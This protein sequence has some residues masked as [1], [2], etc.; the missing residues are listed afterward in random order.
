MQDR[1]YGSRLNRRQFLKLAGA[2]VA[3]LW[4]F[5][6]GSGRARGPVGAGCTMPGREGGLW[7]PR[8]YDFMTHIAEAEVET[9]DPAY[10]QAPEVVWVA[11]EGRF[12]LFAHAPAQVTFR[13]VLVN[14]EGRLEFGVGIHQE[15]WARSGD[16]VRFIVEG[17]DGA[18]RRH[19]LYERHLSPQVRPEDR[20][21][22]DE[23]VDLA[24]FAG[25]R[26]HF[27]FRT[28]PG[29]NN[30][31]DWAVWSQPRLFS[32]LA[33]S[34][35]ATERPNIVL[36]T[37]DTL[38]A[39][40]VSCYGYPRQTTPTLDRLAAEGVRFT[41]AYSQ[42]DHTNPSHTTILTGMYPRS[43]SVTSNRAALPLEVV[44][45]PERL[46]E[47][48]YQTMGA[49]SS[50]HLGPDW[51]MDQG[52]DDYY[53][54]TWERRQGG[55]TTEV[56]LEW[57]IE[58]RQE[59][60]FMWVH[61]FDPHAPYL[62][63]YP[64]NVLYQ[65]DPAY[66][67]YRKP[68]SELQQPYNWV[69]RYGDWPAWAEDVAEVITQYDGA[70]QYADL[71][72]NR[73][74]TYLDEH[75]LSDNTIVIVTADH[76]EG[77]GEHGVAYDHYGLY[78]EV[79]H[80]PLII[81]APGRLPAAQVV[82]ELVGHIDLGPTLFGLLGLPIPEEMAGVDLG[83]TIHRQRGLDRQGIVSQQH[84]LYSTAIRT[85]GWRLIQQL[86]DDDLWP[87]YELHTG[88]VELYDLQDDPQE[89]Q[90]LVSSDSSAVRQTLNSLF[91]LLLG[92]EAETPLAEGLES[93]PLNEEME[94]M[95]RRLGY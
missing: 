11:G 14:E 20:S 75:D 82:D 57:L 81:R 86:L 13:D 79:V 42:S 47:Q 93:P 92:W 49:V 41:H 10:V 34:A 68:T 48:G 80:V 15:A 90:N 17:I 1:D 9:P 52:F 85:E 27:V 3:G 77:F 22:F 39:D 24:K 76:G 89:R 74:L 23:Q 73:L 62:P 25:Q 84:E 88:Q 67:P 6:S 58:K 44:N 18:G 8:Y 51:Q 65:A 35:A 19:D 28:E 69:D 38:R 7:F 55:Q 46:R 5:G 83:Q 16:G 2:A 95:L 29:E 53:S 45:I 60:F 43:H 78:E 61:Y 63:P 31:N 66:T 30:Q 4:L 26:L 21:W 87:L 94:E 56:A 32:A 72:V 40:H 12:G 71:Q 91:D 54:I 37:L 33:E 50:Y 64:Y 70:I 36:I 59:P